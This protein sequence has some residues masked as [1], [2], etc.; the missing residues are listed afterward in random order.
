MRAYVK[1]KISTPERETGGYSIG[2]AMEMH[3]LCTDFLADELEV[4]QEVMRRERISR[5]NG[6]VM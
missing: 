4:I 5:I 6:N 2:Q 3:L 1:G